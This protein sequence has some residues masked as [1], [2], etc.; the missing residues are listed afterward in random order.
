MKITKIAGA[1]LIGMA[2]ISTFSYCTSEAKKAGEKS[3]SSNPTKIEEE[4]DL[5]KPVDTAKYNQLLKKLANGDTTGKWPVKKQPYPL[6]GAIL[7]FKRIVVYYG[8]LHSKKMGALGE[9][10]PKEM[11]QKLNAE[12]KHWEKVDPFLWPFLHL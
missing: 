3:A 10:A 11:W 2:T 6:D 12:V 1:I 4:E 9:Y 7:P 5:R 8:N